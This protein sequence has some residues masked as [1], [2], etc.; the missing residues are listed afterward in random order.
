MREFGTHVEVGAAD[1]AGIL[2]VVVRSITSAESFLASAVAS[3]SFAGEL[4]VPHDH[5]RFAAY[6]AEE[7]S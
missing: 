4:V 7:G 6:S 3:S 2:A 1:G 5:D